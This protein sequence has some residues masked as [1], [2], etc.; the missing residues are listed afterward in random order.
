ML[1]KI[2][3]AVGGFLIL[4]LIASLLHDYWWRCSSE[5][6]SRDA[7]LKS[8]NQKLEV[9]DKKYA[10]KD[11]VLKASEKQGTDWLF[12]YEIKGCTIYIVIDKCGVVDADS[13]GGCS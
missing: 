6:L 1:R 10:T 2:A 5:G 11:F 7:A 13:S 3:K 4:L 9:L 12:T 8:A